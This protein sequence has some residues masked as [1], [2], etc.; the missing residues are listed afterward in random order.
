MRTFEPRDTLFLL[1]TLPR[2]TTGNGNA[3]TISGTCCF[4]RTSRSEQPGGCS[5]VEGYTCAPLNTCEESRRTKRIAGAWT[6]EDSWRSC[7]RPRVKYLK[8]MS[9]QPE[10]P[11]PVEIPTEPP[12]E[13]EE[14]VPDDLDIVMDAIEP[15]DPSEGAGEA[16]SSTE[17][18]VQSSRGTGSELWTACPP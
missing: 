15:I 2:Q 17:I 1:Q 8:T 9:S 7:S 11:P 16:A 13:P 3:R 4:D 5:L 18:E 14:T 6:K 12:R 10:L